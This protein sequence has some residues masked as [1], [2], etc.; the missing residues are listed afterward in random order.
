MSLVGLKPLLAYLR[1]STAGLG[2]P[3]HGFFG[4]FLTW[5]IWRQSVAWILTRAILLLPLLYFARW[6]DEPRSPEMKHASIL[7]LG[8]GVIGLT[9][10]N[11]SVLLGSLGWVIGCGVLARMYVASFRVPSSGKTEAPQL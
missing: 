11:S 9:V 8:V 7:I 10:V 3:K 6:G 4:L 1:S 2:H 5:W